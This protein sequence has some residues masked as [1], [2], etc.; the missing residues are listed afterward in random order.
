MDTYSERLAAKVRA[1]NTA[2]AVA[3]QL[4]DRLAP[5]FSPYQGA[6]VVNKDGSLVHKL[7]KVAEPII[8]EFRSKVH[9]IYKYSV[10]DYN[11]MY[12][13]KTG[14]SYGEHSCVYHEANV[15]IASIRHG[16]MTELSKRPELRSDYS[17]DEISTAKQEY[18]RLKKM[19]N[20]V[21]APYYSFESI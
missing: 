15:Y 16:E 5:V 18:E 8:D 17:A 4:Y 20:I 7:A 14:V 9:H 19:A 21:I 12:V 10:S 11:V 2:N 6:K 3:L 1:V 13:V